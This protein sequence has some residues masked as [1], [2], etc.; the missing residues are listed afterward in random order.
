M[1]GVSINR[2]WTGK[3]NFKD[4]IN[5]ISSTLTHHTVT[6]TTIPIF[7]NVFESFKIFTS[8]HMKRKGVPDFRPII[9][10]TFSAITNLIDFRKPDI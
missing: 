9:S 10:Q 6:S 4:K 5:S 7:N 1:C 3:K 2:C 8:I